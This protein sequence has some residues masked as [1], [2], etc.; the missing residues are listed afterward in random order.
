MRPEDVETMFSQIGQ[1]IAL[2]TKRVIVLEKK[3]KKKRRKKKVL[4]L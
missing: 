1:D 3:L 4:A 2:L